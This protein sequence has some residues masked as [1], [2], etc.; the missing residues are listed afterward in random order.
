MKTHPIREAE[1]EGRPVAAARRPGRPSLSNVDLLDKAF[2][3]FQQHGFEGTSIDAI[4]AATGMAKRTIYARYGD[5]DSLFKAALQRAIEEWLVPVER[6]RAAETDDLEETLLRIGRMLVANIM[7]PA[8]LRLLRITNA[9]SSRRPEIGVFTYNQGTKQTIAYLADLFRRR[10]GPATVPIDEWKEAAI[11]F[12]NSVVSGPSTKTAWGLTFDQAT[13]DKLIVSYVRLFMYG[14]V[15]R[16][17]EPAHDPPAPPPPAGPDD[18]ESAE[19]ASLIEENR[20][21]RKL[22]VEAML[23]N[24]SLRER[25]ENP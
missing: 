22:L 8:G 20:R 24:A 13:I 10:I 23:A 6:L 3:L 16:Q 12:L 25:G 14:L 18:P 5:K 17:G 19:S 4:T 7:N 2:E 11:A 9:E 21:L 15:P 1:S